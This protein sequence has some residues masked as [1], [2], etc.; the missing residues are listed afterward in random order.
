MFYLIG[1]KEVF[2]NIIWLIPFMLNVLGI[3][4]KQP[5]AIVLDIMIAIITVNI[6]LATATIIRF[7]INRRRYPK[8]IE[9]G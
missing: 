3:S 5:S 6:I 9:L 1:K 4:E 8:F 2:G 7:A